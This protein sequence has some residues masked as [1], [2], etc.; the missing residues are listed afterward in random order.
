MEKLILKDKTEILV[1]GGTTTNKFTTIVVGTAGVKS[2][3]DNLTYE[4]LANMELKNEAGIT[5]AVLENKE[6]ENINIHKIEKTDNWRVSVTLKEKDVVMQRLE[7]LEKD[8][9]LQNNAI[10]DISESVYS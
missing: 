6:V 3:L 1:E 7:K 10:A 5:C 4:N 8:Q 9:E 2:F